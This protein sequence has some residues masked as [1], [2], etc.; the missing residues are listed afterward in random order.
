[1]SWKWVEK[2][3]GAQIL[4]KIKANLEFESKFVTQ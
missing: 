1:M 4:L 2:S 3:R